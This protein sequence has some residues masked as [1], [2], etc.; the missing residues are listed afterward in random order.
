MKLRPVCPT[1]VLLQSGHVN[2][3]TPDLL[4]LYGVWGLGIRSFWRVLLVRRV[5]FMSAFL[6][7]LVMKVVSLPTYVPIFVWFYPVFG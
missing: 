5:T 3:Y 1:Y 7:M 4:Y 6:K 2:L